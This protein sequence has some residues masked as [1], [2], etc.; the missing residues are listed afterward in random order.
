MH[1]KLLGVD[2]GTSHFVNFAASLGVASPATTTLVASLCSRFHHGASLSLRL[3]TFH[4]AK[5]GCPYIVM[6]CAM[7]LL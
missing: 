1:G 7:V 6:L 2:F 3:F 5:H 4:T